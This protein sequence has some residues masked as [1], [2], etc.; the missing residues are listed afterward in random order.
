MKRV[1]TKVPMPIPPNDPSP[2][3]VSKETLS[4]ATALEYVGEAESLPNL[5]SERPIGCLDARLKGHK[6]LIHIQLILTQ[7]IRA[8]NRQQTNP[9]V[10]PSTKSTFK[11]L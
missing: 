4:R 9:D 10:A 2:D 5:A 11:P 8:W 1:I 6:T 3:P 7:W